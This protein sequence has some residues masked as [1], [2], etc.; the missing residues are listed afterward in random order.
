MCPVHTL[1]EVEGAKRD[2]PFLTLCNSIILIDCVS[3][4]FLK[5]IKLSEIAAVFA[6]PAAP[7]RLSLLVVY[8]HSVPH[9]R[10]KRCLFV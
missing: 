10:E 8:R 5:A 1:P 4:D 9:Q 7:I 2:I 6:E 3:K